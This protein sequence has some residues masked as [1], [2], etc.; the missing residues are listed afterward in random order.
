MKSILISG[1]LVFSSILMAQNVEESCDS[2]G[3][4]VHATGQEVKAHNKEV[5]QDVKGTLESEKEY[6]SE[7]EADLKA[8][9][10]EGKS[11]RQLLRQ[12]HQNQ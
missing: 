6:V 8:F 11:E 3:T 5:R 10:Q 4:C 2:I 1:V 7:R 12:A 9:H